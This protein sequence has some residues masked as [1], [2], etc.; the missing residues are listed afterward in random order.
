MRATDRSKFLELLTTSS[1]NENNLSEPEEKAMAYSL[2]SSLGELMYDAAS[3]LDG[4]DDADDAIADL[5]LELGDVC[6]RS[7]VPKTAQVVLALAQTL[8]IAIQ[9]TV[10]LETAAA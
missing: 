6:N 10:R 7:S 8:Q 1:I 3:D 5:V 4:L 2:S 9:A